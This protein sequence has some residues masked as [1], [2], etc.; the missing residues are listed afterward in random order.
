MCRIF[1]FSAGSI[2]NIIKRAKKKAG[3]EPAKAGDRL[4]SLE[5]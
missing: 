1:I 5:K 3:I 2:R 4:N